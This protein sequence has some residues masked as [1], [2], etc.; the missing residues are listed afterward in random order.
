VCAQARR[1]RERSGDAEGGAL[2]PLPPSNACQMLHRLLAR[3]SALPTRF[4]PAL[5]AMASGSTPHAGVC[6]PADKIVCLGKK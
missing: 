1:K 3:P 4:I 5:R 2:A 6:R